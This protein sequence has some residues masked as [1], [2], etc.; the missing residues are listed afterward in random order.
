MDVYNGKIKSQKHIGKYALFVSFFP[1]LVAGPIE[2]A[3]NLIP[4]FSENK[5]FNYDRVRSG[6]LLIVWGIFKKVVI[7]D[8]IGIFVSE[9]Y[10]T[11]LESYG[12]INIIATILFS[13]QF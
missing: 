7:A 8:R 13:F 12:V 1:Q 5:I 3:S 4:Q 9:V 2:K 10:N 6:L 11:P